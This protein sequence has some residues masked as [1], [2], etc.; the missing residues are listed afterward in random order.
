LDGA[1]SLLK[2]D[3]VQG[4][5]SNLLQIFETKFLNESELNQT[6]NRNFT[7]NVNKNDKITDEFP[8]ASLDII[9]MTS[10]SHKEKIIQTDRCYVCKLDFS[11]Y[12]EYKQHMI[13]C[14]QFTLSLEQIKFLNESDRNLTENRNVTININK[15][16]ENTVE[17][18]K[19]CLDEIQMTRT[20]HKEKRKENVFDQIISNHNEKLHFAT[21]HEEKNP[22][23]TNVHEE[24]NPSSTSQRM[25]KGQKR[26]WPVRCY[27]CKLD[28]SEY[29]EYKQHM[30]SFHQFTKKSFEQILPNEKELQ[31]EANTAAAHENLNTSHITST[32][33][34]EKVVEPVQESYNWFDI[35]PSIS[36][37]ESAETDQKS[38]LN[39][40]IL[41]VS[42]WM[43]SLP[44]NLMKLMKQ[45]DFP[46]LQLDIEMTSDE[47]E[48]IKENVSKCSKCRNHVFQSLEELNLHFQDHAR[49]V[50]QKEKRKENVFDQIVNIRKEKS[51]EL[52]CPYCDKIQTNKSSLAY[53][54]STLH[55]FKCSKCINQFFQSQEELDLHFQEQHTIPQRFV[56]SIGKIDVIF[57]YTHIHLCV[58]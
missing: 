6:E 52:R 48:K 9:Q 27:V 58:L 36:S 40:N 31:K 46:K 2:I 13:S 28:F 20:S 44:Q 33:H 11:E 26:V 24:E 57:F 37:K 51:E 1:P 3:H 42:N 55:Y 45:A 5:T 41:S 21:V 17:F 7:I 39:P 56:P 19:A 15:S 38:K 8:K 22:H 35:A 47:K 49:A 43:E 4:S 18:P 25:T 34:K 12:G 14:H 16:N 29:G 53:H 10:T 50:T 30:I 32:S 54:I 23:F